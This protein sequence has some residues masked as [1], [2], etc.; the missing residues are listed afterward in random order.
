MD[1]CYCAKSWSWPKFTTTY[2]PTLPLE[3]ASLQDSTILKSYIYIRKILIGS[4]MFPRWGD[5][6]PGA[7]YSTIFPESY[8][9]S[10]FFI[11]QD[12][13]GR[14]TKHNYPL[15]QWRT[16]G[17]R[18]KVICSKPHS[19]QRLAP[20]L[21]GSLSPWYTV[22]PLNCGTPSCPKVYEGAGRHS[23]CLSLSH[24]SVSSSCSLWPPSL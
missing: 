8:L 12:N 21:S 24:L 9:H 7:S 23:L 6:F 2:H 14:Q 19:S 15:L 4:A 18:G 5:R 3:V 22:L 13:P 11:N 16:K 20:T 17:Q 1:N 10:L